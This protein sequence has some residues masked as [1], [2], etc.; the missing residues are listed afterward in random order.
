MHNSKMGKLPNLKKKKNWN[1]RFQKLNLPRIS[2]KEQM[3]GK[4][5]TKLR[6]SNTQ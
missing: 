5:N 1:P 3:K 4:E 2:L 6:S